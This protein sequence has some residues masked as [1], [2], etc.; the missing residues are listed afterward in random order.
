MKLMFDLVTL[1][2]AKKKYIKIKIMTMYS[3]IYISFS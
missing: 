2:D 3:Y 1:V